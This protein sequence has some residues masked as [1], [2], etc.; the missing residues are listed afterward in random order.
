[1]SWN[2]VLPSWSQLDEIKCL[3]NQVNNQPLSSI[4]LANTVAALTGTHSTQITIPFVLSVKHTNPVMDQL[5][6]ELELK[7]FFDTI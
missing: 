6:K 1:M 2:N 3:Q 7:R 5:T 4:V